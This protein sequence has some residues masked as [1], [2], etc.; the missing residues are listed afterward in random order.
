MNQTSSLLSTKITQNRTIYF[1]SSLDNFYHKISNKKLKI[2]SPLNNKER[3]SFYSSKSNNIN[4]ISDIIKLYKE[5]NKKEKRN[6]NDEEEYVIKKENKINKG[7]NVKEKNEEDNIVT[8]SGFNSYNQI[9]LKN[10]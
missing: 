10:L 9:I 7:I 3:N 6:M 2:T 5:E 8:S 4:F 1:N